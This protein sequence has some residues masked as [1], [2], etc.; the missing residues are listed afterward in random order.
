MQGINRD[1]CFNSEDLKIMKNAVV[2]KLFYFSLF[3]FH[4]S[5]LV[6]HFPLPMNMSDCSLGYLMN[7]N[8]KLM[9]EGI[10]RVV[11][12]FNKKKG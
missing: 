10:R 12:D 6:F 3:T 11:N 5:L 9:K 4:F 8:V 1:A 2:R 7:F